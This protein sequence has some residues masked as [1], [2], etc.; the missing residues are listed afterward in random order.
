MSETK[1]QMHLNLFMT[2]AGHHEAAWR[3][4][5]T[6]PRKLT[7]IQYY[8][9]LA[10]L[11]EQY[12]FDSVFLSDGLATGNQKYGPTNNFFEPIT[13][14]TSVAT[15]TE[16]IG[17]IGT[18]SSTYSEPYNLARQFASLDHISNGRAAW[19]IVTTGSEAAAHNFNK[20]THLEHT[21][22]YERAN[23]FLEVATALWDSWEDE[24][25]IID[26]EAGIFTDENKIREINHVGE[27][28][29][30]RGPL[31]I[32]RPPQGYPVLVQA[33][34]SE[35]GREF[36]AKYAEVIFTT[37]Q[38]LKEAQ[39]FYADVKGRMAHYGRLPEQLNIMPGMAPIIGRTEAEAKEKEQELNELI[40]P[41]WGLNEL[42]SL[43]GVDMFAY[44]LDG[45]LPELP[46]SN[47]INGQRSKYKLFIDL[48]KRENLTIRQLLHR[49]AAGR[50]HLTIVGTGSQIADQ[51]EEWFVKRG[52]DG[53]NVMPAYFPEGLV[54][55]SQMVIPELQR[56]GLFRTEYTGHTLRDHFGLLKPVNQFST[57]PTGSR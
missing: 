54:E 22:R 3:H 44:P 31:N 5:N 4:K 23:E 1:R 50:G 25:I 30:V 39:E 38:I 8:Q 49:T 11:A 7:N 26:R 10:Q 21:K 45:P 55:F 35:D 57:I 43:V 18:V 51:L 28:F 9:D 47:E 24:A 2:R 40:M 6:D 42:S 41:E 46:D 12:K 17:L 13:L 32:P 36:A 20:D 34:S 19:N 56:R 33:G 15:V 29:Q 48:A 16:R 37:Q 53:F 52:C 14:L 27:V